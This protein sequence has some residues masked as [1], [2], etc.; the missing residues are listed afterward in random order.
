MKNIWLIFT[1]VFGLG[2]FVRAEPWEERLKPHKEKY[3]AGWEIELTPPQVERIVRYFE[4]GKSYA[5]EGKNLTAEHFVGYLS[6]IEAFNALP[7]VVRKKLSAGLDP[8]RMILLD[9]E[10]RDEA[11][12]RNLATRWEAMPLADR[13][14]H[15]KAQF[16][17]PHA[18]ARLFL[19]DTDLVTLR[20]DA[21]PGLK[22][23]MS[24]LEYVRDQD[25]V[26]FRMTSPLGDL[27][28]VEN[29]RRRFAEVAG[30]LQG[31]DDTKQVAKNGGASYHLHISTKEKR[32]LRSFLETYNVLQ[33]VRLT[34][35][36]RT[37]IFNLNL[38]GYRPG[39][40]SRGLVRLIDDNHFE[41]RTHTMEPRDEMIEV[42]DWLAMPD[43]EADKKMW[44]EIRRQWTADVKRDFLGAV[45]PEHY[46]HIALVAASR[47]QGDLFELKGSY[48]D[49]AVRAVADNDVSL[50][51]L[52]TYEDAIPKGAERERV[53]KDVRQ[54][55]LTRYHADFLK[56][57]IA[58]PEELS[59]D[60]FEHLR[61]ALRDTPVKEWPAF[62]RDGAMAKLLV[63]SLPTRVK[64]FPTAVI[65]LLAELAARA[66]G[67]EPILWPIALQGLDRTDA[68]LF[69]Q[70]L[71]R[72][73]DSDP[74]LRDRFA[75]YLRNPP[76][77]YSRIR[78]R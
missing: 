15:M 13:R 31:F 62:I 26:E 50:E 40:I 30:I 63:E 48:Y 25:T 57:E 46:L 27:V 58:S 17:P 38:V 3:L 37:D 39:L 8:N 65:D 6:S 69:V 9:G 20:E 2:A 42:A 12:L 18:L 32:N 29:L 76:C 59:Q 1:L 78:P 47:G 21:P 60:L 68:F 71:R 52:M 23:L 10:S 77:P 43:G 4:F 67:L 11:Y 41:I 36:G 64:G 45:K 51:A 72:F 28:E 54:A 19:L 34:A 24:Y 70:S 53:L 74:A 35:G 55:V 66:P 5:E 75:E 44:A 56:R 33:A 7:E 61:W 22:N 16:L 73:Y 49:R 14:P